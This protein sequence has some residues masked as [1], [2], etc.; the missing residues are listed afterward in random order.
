MQAIVQYRYGSPD[1]LEIADIPVPRM[2][3]DEVL[4]R[5]PMRLERALVLNV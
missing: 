1:V 3:N 2:G 5:I 4:V